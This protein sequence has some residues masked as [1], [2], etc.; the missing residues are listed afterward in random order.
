MVLA[1]MYDETP[2][3]PVK[4]PAVMTVGHC[5]KKWVSAGKIHGDVESLVWE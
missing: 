5:P 3:T 4:S 2:P 1:I